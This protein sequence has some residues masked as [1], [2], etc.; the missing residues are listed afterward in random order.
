MFMFVVWF[1]VF[2][3]IDLFTGFVI[4]FSENQEHLM[5]QQLPF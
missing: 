1:M 3:S 2:I 4:V 5:R